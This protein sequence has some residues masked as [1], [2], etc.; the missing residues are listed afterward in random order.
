[1]QFLCEHFFSSLLTYRVVDWTEPQRHAFGVNRVLRRK[2]NSA[3]VIIGRLSYVEFLDQPR[4]VGRPLVS[5]HGQGLP[6]FPRSAPS[7]LGKTSRSVLSQDLARNR[8]G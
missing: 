6:S 5:C 4:N 2:G 1:M 7:R 8:R 3:T